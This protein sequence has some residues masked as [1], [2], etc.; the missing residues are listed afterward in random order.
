MLLLVRVAQVMNLKNFTRCHIYKLP[1]YYYYYVDC[2][3]SIAH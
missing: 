3:G 1:F 2:A